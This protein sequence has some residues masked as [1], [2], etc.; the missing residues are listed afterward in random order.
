MHLSHI[1]Y[2]VKNMEEAVKDFEN[3]GFTVI[4]G[5]HNYNIWF[6]D[7]TFIELFSI[8]KKPFLIFLFRIIGMKGMANKMKYFQDADVG[9]I[10]YSLENKVDDLDKENEQLKRLGYKFTSFS[11]RKKNQEGEKLKW[12]IT[13]PYDLHLPFM[14]ASKSYRILMMPDKISHKNGAKKLKKLVWGVHKDYIEDIQ[15]LYQ[16]NRLELV[17]GSGFKSIEIEGLEDDIFHKEYYK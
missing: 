5:G 13:F 4:R 10:E 8:K 16:D 12:K 3:M 15:S 1:L 17:E 11:M 9:F 2:K 14:V 6:E 7:G